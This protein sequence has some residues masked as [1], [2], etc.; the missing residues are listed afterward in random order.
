MGHTDRG[1]PQALQ[2]ERQLAAGPS[3]SQSALLDDTNL[4]GPLGEFLN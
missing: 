4:Q 1:Q 2:G 3:T